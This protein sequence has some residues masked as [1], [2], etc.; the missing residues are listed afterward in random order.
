MLPAFP[1]SPL[2][3]GYQGADGQHERIALRLRGRFVDERTDAGVIFIV[4]KVSMVA[5]NADRGLNVS[6][7]HQ[8]FLDVVESRR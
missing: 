8:I 3:Q 1:Q 4:N 2:T 5:I 7:L 6:F